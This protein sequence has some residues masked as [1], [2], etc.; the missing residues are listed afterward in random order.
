[1][2]AKADPHLAS[3]RSLARGLRGEAGTAGA[4]G[5][6]I[7]QARFHV[8]SCLQAGDDD[9]ARRWLDALDAAVVALDP[10]HRC[11]D[12]LERAVRELCEVVDE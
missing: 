9:G 5:R 4:L 3:L 7:E 6:Q 11:R 8:W 1:M 10:D 2:S 12:H